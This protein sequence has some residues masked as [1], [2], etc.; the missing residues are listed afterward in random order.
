MAGRGPC[1]AIRLSIYERN[2]ASTKVV[3][4]VTKSLAPRSLINEKF[5]QEVRA[6]GDRGTTFTILL[7]W[8]E[9][10]ARPPEKDGRDDR[11]PLAGAIC[12]R[13]TESNL[14][15]PKNGVSTSQANPVADIA[16]L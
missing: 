16:R 9:A 14:K 2:N 6:P 13:W 5:D 4:I 8:A 7:S 3:R 1:S 11:S 12:G 15:K 10:L